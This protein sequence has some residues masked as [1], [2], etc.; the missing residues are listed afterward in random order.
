M[1]AAGSVQSAG[2][3]RQEVQVTAMGPDADPCT[4]QSCVPPFRQGPCL[5]CLV[6]A[7]LCSGASSARQRPRG[8]AGSCCRLNSLS[9]TPLIILRGSLGT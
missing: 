2:D 5:A 3:G 9:I 1:H 6:E 7:A 4:W 8:S